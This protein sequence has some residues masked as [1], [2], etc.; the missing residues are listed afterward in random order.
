MDGPC[1]FARQAD[2]THC[3]SLACP[4]AWRSYPLELTPNGQLSSLTASDLP[5]AFYEDD[6]FRVLRLHP[7]GGPAVGGTRLHVYLTDDRCGSR[8]NTHPA[9]SR[10]ICGADMLHV[11]TDS[12]GAGARVTCCP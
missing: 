10:P 1:P 7:I 11:W 12:R 2:G 9:S 8:H 4:P 6:V 5:F 3:L